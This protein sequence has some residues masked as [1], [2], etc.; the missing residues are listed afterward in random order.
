[1]FHE[2]PLNYL[3][4]CVWSFIWFS[5]TEAAKHWIRIR[6]AC[7]Q[8]QDTRQRPTVAERLF[9]RLESR[10]PN[11]EANTDKFINIQIL[12]TFPNVEKKIATEEGIFFF[13][14]FLLFFS[15]II[16]FSYSLMLNTKDVLSGLLSLKLLLF[17]QWLYFTCLEAAG[18]P[19]FSLAE[20]KRN[21]Y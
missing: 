14:L 4:L 17:L 11:I 20:V 13:K 16:R 7:L 18:K 3:N 5:R 19:R 2:T 12:N 1:M 10:E 9:L 21:I 6:R 8:P 15:A